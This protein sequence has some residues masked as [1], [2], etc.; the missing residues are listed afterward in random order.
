MPLECSDFHLA[1]H[2][3]N[4]RVWSQKTFGPAQRPMGVVDHI[5]KELNEIRAAPHDLSEWIDVVI[6]AF[7]GA[8]RQG[9]HP[10]DVVRA[11]IAKQAK[12]ETRTWPDWR[13]QDPNKATEHVKAPGV[14]IDGFAAGGLVKP[15][16]HP[17]KSRQHVVEVTIDASKLEAAFAEFAKSHPTG[18]L[19]FPPEPEPTESVAKSRNVQIY[20][21]L[22]IVLPAVALAAWWIWMIS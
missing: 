5:E 17:I 11:L 13:T 14:L 20:W 4:Q 12:N 21:A 1:T 19:R 7:D 3:E 9:H 8:M 16:S 2:L 10:A 18:L 6:L 15:R 22:V